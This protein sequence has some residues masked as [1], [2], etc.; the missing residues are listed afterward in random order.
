MVGVNGW[1]IV[2]DKLFPYLIAMCMASLAAF[3][4]GGRICIA[5]L[6]ACEE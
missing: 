2:L 5:R 1:K 3:F 6:S 4:F